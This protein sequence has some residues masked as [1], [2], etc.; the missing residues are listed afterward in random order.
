MNDTAAPATKT[1]YPP[2]EPSPSFPRIEEAIGAAWEQEKT[3]QRSIDQRR[4]QGAPEYVFYDG[5]PFA[6]GLPH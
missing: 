5:P 6:N 1:V 4:E 2:A 3:F